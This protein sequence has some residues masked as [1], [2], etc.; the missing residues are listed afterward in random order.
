M[1]HMMKY[2]L[3]ICG[4]QTYMPHTFG[5]YIAGKYAEFD[6]MYN[7]HMRHAYAYVTYI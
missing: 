2:A 6:K 7:K 1:P 5:T 4:M 3:N